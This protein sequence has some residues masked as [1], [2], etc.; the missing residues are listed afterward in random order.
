M[1]EDVASQDPTSLLTDA[2]RARIREEEL[3]RIRELARRREDDAR[4]KD[5][6][7]RSRKRLEAEA[8]E[9][10]RKD[11]AERYRATIRAQEMARQGM[12]E[13]EGQ[14]LTPEE[15]AAIAARKSRDVKDAEEARGRAIERK[16]ARESEKFRVYEA[17]KIV[18]IKAYCV[19]MNV[20]IG[21]FA[22]GLVL[23]GVAKFYLDWFIFGS[24]AF[25]L[26]GALT[27]GVGFKMAS[28]VEMDLHSNATFI[29]ENQVYT[30]A[31]ALELPP[32]LARPYGWVRWFVLKTIF[33]ESTKREVLD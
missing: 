30:V 25:L 5:A 20:G 26:M 21:L 18:E 4:E 6:A 13:V 31:R 2:E 10:A 1:A 7:E 33:K 27:F 22:F 3:G 8:L 28:E 11:E 14:W 32:A 29:V 17:S 16:V 19:V 15:A 9:A 23:F 24:F 12:V